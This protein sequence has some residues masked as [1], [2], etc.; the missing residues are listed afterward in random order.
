MKGS[1]EG[2]DAGVGFTLTAVP[3][4]RRKIKGPPFVLWRYQKL[5]SVIVAD[6][7]RG[8]DVLIDAAALARPGG[9]TYDVEAGSARVFER[10]ADGGISEVAS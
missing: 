6:G 9:G 10:G 3:L 1:W 2:N 7:E 5:S 8:G 4:F